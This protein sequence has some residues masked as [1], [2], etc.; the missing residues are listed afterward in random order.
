VGEYQAVIKPL[1]ASFKGQNFLSGASILGDGSIALLL[2]TEK[3]K[4]TIQ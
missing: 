3:L 1:G 2:D 4:L